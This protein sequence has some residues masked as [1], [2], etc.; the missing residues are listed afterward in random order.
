MARNINSARIGIVKSNQQSI[1]NYNSVLRLT[2][3][4]QQSTVNS[5]QST[6]NSQQ[7]T[8]NSQQ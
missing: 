6:I 1:L 7:S 2:V 5:Q 3:N 8:V 4:S